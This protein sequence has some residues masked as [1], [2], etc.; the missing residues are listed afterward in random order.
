MRHNRAYIC[1]LLVFIL[2]ASNALATE[3]SGSS[4]TIPYYYTD[5][6]RGD[7]H[8]HL[9]LYEYAQFGAYDLGAPGIEFYFSGWGRWDTLDRL[10][11][12][13]KEIGDA[14]LSSGYFRYRQE[15]GYID[16]SVGR[17]FVSMGP[18]AERIDGGYA[19]LEPYPN[20]G[21]QGFGGVP[22]LTQVG[23]RS[24]DWAAGGRAFGGWKH[25][26]QLGFSAANFNEKG[27]PDR[28]RLG[29]D[30][31]VLSPKWFDLSGHT[32]FDVLY[33]S[34]Y[35]EDITLVVRPI[36]DLKILGQYQH[37][38][39][40]AYIG[41]GSI[42]S[43]FSFDS[44]SKANTEISYTVLRRVVLSAHYNNY[45]YDNSE[46]GHRYGGSAGVLWGENRT[47]TFDL[48]VFKLDR[49]NDGYLELRGYLFQRMIRELFLT[50][51]AVGYYLD[52]EI[53][54]T[55]LGFN[56]AG[57]FG[58]NVTEDLDIQATGFYAV[59]PYYNMDFRGLLK[60]AYRFSE[61]F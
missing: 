33:Y 15:D 29:G 43:V 54:G 56:G 8:E 31:F 55:R 57:S 27:E 9:A 59:S 10:E 58:W 46:M 20:V 45:S 5:T 35:D 36:E 18:V 60:V 28:L 48:G 25:Y 21:I 14:D 7:E 32:Y 50:L 40:S 41:M 44:I 34:M 38:M 42:F 24:G 47:D 2:Y 22:V 6:E 16:A 4:T 52:K 49:E 17:R 19:Q 61:I 1:I 53:Y 13:Q 3:I 23:D 51:D 26:F 37:V 39:P 12:D 30:F 11:M